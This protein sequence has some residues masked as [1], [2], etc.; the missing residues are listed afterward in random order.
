VTTPDAV[1]DALVE[2]LQAEFGLQ[3]GSYRV[4][5]PLFSSGLLDSFALVALLAFA[6]ERFGLVV[7]TEEITPKNIDT[8]SGIAAFIGANSGANSTGARLTS[9]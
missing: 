8:V 2:F 7:A 3:R 4:D 6:E 1:E 5:E 9:P